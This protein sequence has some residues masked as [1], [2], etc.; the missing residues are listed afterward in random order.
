[1]HF[2]NSCLNFLV[3]AF[4]SVSGTPALKPDFHNQAPR[5]L[6]YSISLCC[7]APGLRVLFILAAQSCPTL[8][9]RVEK[10][11]DAVNYNGISMLKL[12]KSQGQTVPRCYE[13]RWRINFPTL[14]RAA[15]SENVQI[16][17]ITIEYQC[18][19]SNF[20]GQQTPRC[21]K[22]QWKINFQHS[23]AGSESS[24]MLQITIKYHCSNSN[25]RVRKTPR[26]CKLQW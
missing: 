26:C 10:L 17:Y 20:Q 11:P 9:C 25:S 21:F 22:L 6:F 4:C 16:L 18:S 1:M 3:T 23:L 12:S 14:T 15:G 13:L 24:Q 5:E 19:N 2:H 8:T 7:R